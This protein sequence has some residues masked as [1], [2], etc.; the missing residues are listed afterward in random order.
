[1]TTFTSQGQRLPL[2]SLV[3]KY[4]L[5]DNNLNN[6]VL[7][8]IYS[9]KEHLKGMLKPSL[10]IPQSNIG[11]WLSKRNFHNWNEPGIKQLF[12]SFKDPITD[13]INYMHTIHNMATNNNYEWSHYS[14]V[15]FLPQYAY[16]AP[17]THPGSQISGCYYFSTPLPNQEHPFSGR[18]DFIEDKV[19]TGLQ[20]EKGTLLLFPSNLLHWVHPNYNAE[21]RISLSLNIMSI[22][23][24][25]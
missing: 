18:I 17:H 7:Q 11:G 6:K 21:D 16:N 2:D 19:E 3:I 14:W 25:N 15:N 23:K 9:Q 24:I 22:K 8:T 12:N 4:N 20:P 13:Y 1:M 5:D 10:K